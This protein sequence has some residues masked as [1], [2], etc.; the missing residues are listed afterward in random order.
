M[1]K[2]KNPRKGLRDFS[3][4]TQ[5]LFYKKTFQYFCY[6]LA[7][8]IIVSATAL[9]YINNNNIFAQPQESK[10][11]ELIINKAIQD[12]KQEPIKSIQILESY[13]NLPKLLANRKHYILTK[14]YQQI[15]EPLVAL[16]HA[17]DIDQDYLTKYS[18][19]M[20]Y[21][22]AEKIGLEASV[23]K[24]LDF[25]S[26]KY[27]KEI[28]F[29]YELAKSY[30][31][32]NRLLEAKKNFKKIQELFPD[33]EYALGADYYLA[34][35]SKDPEEKSSRLRNYLTKSPNGS[36]AYLI[37]DQIHNLS[38]GS[39][40]DLTNYIALSYFYREDY[41]EAIK[42]F[43][44]KL[45][46]AD[47]YLEGYAT[48]LIKLE[49]STEA[50]TLL[51]SKLAEIND[52]EKAT[53]LLDLLCSS[54]STSEAAVA[55]LELLKNTV[56]S[57]K[58]KILWEIAIRTDDK[59]IYQALYQDYPDS[60][61]AAE[62]MSRVFWKEYQ[63]KNYHKAIE[64]FKEHWKNYPQTNSHAFVAFWA[65]R[66]YE[67]LDQASDAKAALQNLII[68]HPRDYYGYR[69]KQKLAKIKDWYKL[70]GPNQF[71]NVPD[72][73]WP[74]VY[75][76]DTI[77]NLYGTDVVE[78]CEIAEYDFLLGNEL[79]N[80]FDFDTNFKMWLY[81]KAG[82]HLK[83]ISTAYFALDKNAKVDYEE[84]KFHY[85]YPMPYAGIIADETSKN[86][87]ID[88]S[89]AH[90]LIKQ[91]SRYQKDIVSKAGAIGLMQ[92]MPYTARAIASSLQIRPPRASDL[93]DPEINIKLG[94]YYMEDVFKA[95]DNNMIHAIASYNAGPAA[96]Q[97]WKKR[98]ASE[99]PD[100]F[101][102]N[103]PY[104][105]TKNYVKRILNNFWVYKELYG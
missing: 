61:Y 49:R 18:H 80:D 9:Y 99:D 13:Q 89:L 79:T 68:E 92:L 97:G 12:S 29:P 2:K 91:E 27:P 6:A 105:E 36:F 33:S 95:F 46:N 78:L 19:V 85:A 90:A 69:A 3:K 67:A 72:W 71:V 43:D 51:V 35:L 45:D 25:L 83:A 58:D 93:M 96:V 66:A 60:L 8:F 86:L 24:D 20:R 4:S 59:E 32:Q 39:F 98:F 73:D 81:A 5:K 38:N 76:K 41:R 10:E 65:A 52:Q 102:E 16:I 62:S 56:P 37:S 87:K 21:K 64:L 54:S 94:I 88:P 77:K 101:I 75:D 103:I 70:P 63:R 31:R 14:L 28:R 26:K 15:D 74:E 53:R 100:E 42:F 47:L 17:Y 40:A 50:Q 84:L 22:L 55:N 57:I 48:T 23:A 7:A 34:N 30:L 11:L 44:T 1:A 82:D 104:N